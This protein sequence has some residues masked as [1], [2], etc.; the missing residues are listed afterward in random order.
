M[1]NKLLKRC[2]PWQQSGR[3][4]RVYYDGLNVPVPNL[5]T[6]RCPDNMTATVS[7]DGKNVNITYDK[8]VVRVISYMT[9]THA[10]NDVVPED[11][12]IYPDLTPLR[13]L[14]T[15]GYIDMYV[16]EIEVI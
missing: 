6:F 11:N 15:K 2:M 13:M 8:P 5:I 3:W 4:V 10:R 1:L 14:G 12:F 16:R 9:I 7:A